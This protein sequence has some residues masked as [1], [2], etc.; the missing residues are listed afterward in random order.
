[1]PRFNLLA[2][3]RAR[4]TML[5]CLATIFLSA[6]ST[7]M[8]ARRRGRFPAREADEST[9]GITHNNPMT[10]WEAYCSTAVQ[11][12][13]RLL[14]SIFVAKKGSLSIE[15][16]QCRDMWEAIRTR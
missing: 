5:S 12:V 1:M 3:D 2:H 13:H 11:I 7:A 8:K 9:R 10:N 6:F 4:Q 14:L 16:Y 15:A